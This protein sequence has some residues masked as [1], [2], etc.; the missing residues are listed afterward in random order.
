[1]EAK[2]LFG[3][4]GALVLC[5]GGL[6]AGLGALAGPASA[7]VTGIAPPPPGGAGGFYDANGSPITTAYTGETVYLTVTVEQA[8]S[9]VT[10]DG[11]IDLT[12]NPRDFALVGTG[13]DSSG[14][15][16]T[17]PGSLTCSYTDMATTSKSVAYQF[18][19]LGPDAHASV[20]ATAQTD[21]APQSENFPLDIEAPL[22]L[23]TP[24][25]TG[26]AGWYNSSGA[27]ITQAQPGQS[28]SLTVTALQPGPE[29]ADGTFTLQWNTADFTYQ[30]NGDH[31]AACTPSTTGTTGSVACSY[32]DLAH[33]AKSD[34]FYFVTGGPDARASVSATVT[35]NGYSASE[36][37]PLDITTAGPVTSSSVPTSLFA[38]L[39]GG[40]RHLTDAQGHPFKNQGQCVSY[41]E[42]YR[43]Y[44]HFQGRADACGQEGRGNG[45]NQGGSKGD[46]GDHGQDRH[47]G[48]CGTGNQNNQ[49]NQ[50]GDGHGGD[51]GHGRH[52]KGGHLARRTE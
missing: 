36:A 15:C 1:M 40:W 30:G 7:T 51:W 17:A 4:L 6:V 37:F 44:Q 52:G 38:C 35:V 18:S 2:R 27:P 21:G 29:Y 16:S 42:H 43:H 9:T 20:L 8:G 13:N 26:T 3:G 25:P 32:T 28:V 12:W 34:S 11:T 48:T 24:P 49:G 22:S 5:A 10:G 47:D 50:G 19:V 23:D 45:G 39:R 41:F 33:S 14:A 46:H 31:T